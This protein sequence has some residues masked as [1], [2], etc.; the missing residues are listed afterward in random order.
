MSKSAG[1]PQW[2][3]DDECT[4]EVGDLFSLRRRFVEELPVLLRPHCHAVRSPQIDIN[5]EMNLKAEMNLMDWTASGRV[6]WMF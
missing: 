1:Q 4:D 3:M 6:R 2:P 5:V